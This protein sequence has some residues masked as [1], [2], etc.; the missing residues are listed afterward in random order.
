[1]LV[2]R[3][4]Q[5]K[6]LGNAAR[7]EFIAALSQHAGEHFP[8]A[9]STMSPDEVEELCEEAIER[10]ATFG[11]TGQREVCLWLNLMLTFGRDF[12]SQPWASA[13]LRDPAQPGPRVLM[14]RLY[15]LAQSQLA[16]KAG[17]A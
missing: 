2:I 12:E 1:M 17:G 15:R 10:S 13:L 6:A 14:S 9:L 4:A 11:V 3:H 8:A 16:A 7:Q 5:W